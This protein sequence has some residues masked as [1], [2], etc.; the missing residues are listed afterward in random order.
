MNNYYYTFGANEQ[1]PYQNGWIVIQADTRNT[2]DTIFTHFYPNRN[3][4]NPL[5]NCS[6]V[7]EENDFKRTSMYKNNSNMGFGCHK[8]F[9]LHHNVN[10]NEDTETYSLTIHINPH[11][12]QKMIEKAYKQNLLYLTKNDYNELV[13]AIKYPLK[14]FQNWFYF[15]DNPDCTNMS[16][17][18]YKRTTP[19]SEI[20]RKLYDTIKY[21]YP[22]PEYDYY[23]YIMKEHTCNNLTPGQRFV[24]MLNQPNPSI[25]VDTSGSM[26]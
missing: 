2:A 9:T 16:V 14:G 4:N 3:P 6:F 25:I 10:R 20:T 1:F 17:K 5:L 19:I 24:E 15:E 8:T 7:Y 22:S 23:Y 18:E 21:L 11:I 12:T 26:G 13:A